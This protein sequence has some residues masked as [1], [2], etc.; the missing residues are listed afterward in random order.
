MFEA[1]AFKNSNKAS[2]LLAALE[3][4]KNGGFEWRASP[5]ASGA[6]RGPVR[7]SGGAAVYCEREV[8]YNS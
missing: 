2:W 8:I 3:N 5:G 6:R 4:G 1:I 7:P